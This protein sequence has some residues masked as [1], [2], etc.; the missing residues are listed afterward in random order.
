MWSILDVLEPASKYLEAAGVENARFDAELVLADVLKISRLDLYLQ[1]ERLL[2][3]KERGVFRTMLKQRQQRIP[4]QHILG[5]TEFFSLPFM[6][7]PG[8]FIPRQETELLVERTL[9]S[10]ESHF[11]SGG[12]ALNGGPLRAVEMGVGS[13]VISVSLAHNRTD[14]TIWASDI[15]AEALALTAENARLNQV[16]MRIALEEQEGLPAGNGSPLHLIVSNP[17]YI[18]LDEAD[19][20]QPEVRDHDPEAALFGGE[21]GL[22]AYRYLAAAGPSRLHDGGIMAVEIGAD[23]GEAVTDI[24]RAGGFGEIALHRDY[25]GRDR[26]VIARKT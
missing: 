5:N 18:R 23:Q 11:T 22:D 7:R 26:I 25:A 9:E 17:P 19:S 8:V 24:L 15:S 12:E 21:D 10:L 2:T 16:E 4:L 20:L 3:D 6:V 14:M 13:G 1:Y